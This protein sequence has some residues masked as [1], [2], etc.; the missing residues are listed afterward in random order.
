MGQRSVDKQAQRRSQP[1]DPG[2]V[3][4]MPKIDPNLPHD[5]YMALKEAQ[6]LTEWEKVNL[7]SGMFTDFDKYMEDKRSNAIRSS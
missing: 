5:V 1:Q 4:K 6:T 3:Q 7:G 2:G